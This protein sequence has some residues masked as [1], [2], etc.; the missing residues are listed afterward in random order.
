MSYQPQS[1]LQSNV[2]PIVSIIKA[3]AVVTPGVHDSSFNQ[4]FFLSAARMTFQKCKAGYSPVFNTLQQLP[5]S[6]SIKSAPPSWTYTVFHDLVPAYFFSFSSSL[7]PNLSFSHI[8]LS[9]QLLRSSVLSQLCRLSTGCFLCVE[10][11]CV[12]FC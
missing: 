1:S 7:S 8:E 2:Q 4:F 9:L 6:F 10:C 5:V 12:S 11:L 3:L